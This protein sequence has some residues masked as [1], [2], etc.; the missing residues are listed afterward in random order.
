VERAD[1][2]AEVKEGTLCVIMFVV[3]AV[4]LCCAECTDPE[5]VNKGVLLAIGVEALPGFDST[6]LRVL[7]GTALLG[8]G[9]ILPGAAVLSIVEVSTP[10][11]DTDVGEVVPEQKTLKYASAAWTSVSV[12][13][14]TR[15]DA[16]ELAIASLGQTQLG[17]VG[18]QPK[19]DAA[20]CKH[21]STQG[22]G[23][24]SCDKTFMTNREAIMK[25][26]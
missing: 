25:V 12:H 13:W 10:E 26:R 4:V 23:G 20:V 19:F 17:S 1:D 14:P 21:A 6:L 2:A 18:K 11:R 16:T 22:G 24:G 15:H 8:V 3:G 9:S 5:D 7:V